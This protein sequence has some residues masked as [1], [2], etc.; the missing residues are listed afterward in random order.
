MDELSPLF[1][2]IEFNERFR[3][4]DVEEVDAYVDRVAKAAA[5]VQG[6]IAELQERVA[7]AE[8][9]PRTVVT[10]NPAPAG[11]IDDARL[12]RVLV[13]AQRTADA[14]IEEAKAE[15]EAMRIDAGADA[16]RMRR[17]A[18]D[19]A[20]LVLAEAETDRRRMINEAEEAAAGAVAAER[21]RVAAEVA[22]LEQHRAVLADDIAILEQHLAEA[23]LSAA[24]SVS[25]LSDLL[26]APESFRT[27]TAPV[28]SGID[29]PQD[30][31]EG[32]YRPGATVAEPAPTPEAEPTAEPAPAVD[33]VVD[34]TVEPIDDTAAMASDGEPT[35]VFETIPFEP[36]IDGDF[37]P[38]AVDESFEPIAP[39]IEADDVIADRSAGEAN[40]E[41]A[42]DT[43]ATD[44][45]PPVDREAVEPVAEVAAVAEEPVEAE[46]NMV[47][48]IDLV[49]PDHTAPI[50]DLTDLPV[51]AI[52][53]VESD[54]I[55]DL[56]PPEPTGL[57]GEGA[58]ATAPPRLVTAEDI[59][60]SDEAERIDELGEAGATPAIPVEQDL[61]FAPPESTANDHFLD[62][63]RD[64]VSTDDTED[65]G[66]DALA[67]FFDDGE[68]G[69]KGGWFNRRR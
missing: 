41:P 7:A 47:F 29:V 6:R 28:T 1:H 22:E 5:L 58:T 69:D 36:A 68:D 23:R 54:R 16:E 42:P 35:Q 9:Q 45:A 61:L 52:G 3:G 32:R 40:A 24:A 20:S 38:M 50:V 57:D 26:E 49:D 55:A 37:S 11:E 62:Q 43:P 15:A 59:D 33:E 27:P 53:S 30:L 31:I 64:A 10:S 19:H 8:A 44:T 4:Y 25:A 21:A 12:S 2:D 56:E 18:D 51:D 60:S 17:E 13:L 39:A 67:A 48:D 14:A 66:E 63:L 46:P 34:L 65:F